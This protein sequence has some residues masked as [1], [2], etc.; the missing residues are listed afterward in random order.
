VVI[1]V[2][3]IAGILLVLALCP[4]SFPELTLYARP[5]QSERALSYNTQCLF[6][7]PFFDCEE[8]HDAN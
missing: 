5:V 1:L 6:P 7:F 2:P 8:S 3:V 4:T